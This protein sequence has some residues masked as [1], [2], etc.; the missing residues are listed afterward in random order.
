MTLGIFIIYQ[1]QSPAA[2]I[3]MFYTTRQVKS[4]KPKQV[5]TH[6]MER[7][8]S[9]EANRFSASPEIPRI[10]W[11]PKVHYRIHKCLPTVLIL[12]LLDPVHIPTSY[13]LKIHLN[14][15]LPSTPGSPKWSFSF[16]FPPPKPCIRLSCP[17]YELHATPNSFFSILSPEQNNTSTSNCNYL[18]QEIKM[19]RL[20]Y[21]WNTSYFMLHILINCSCESVVSS[22]I[23]N[24][25]HFTDGQVYTEI[26]TKLIQ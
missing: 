6:S 26:Y 11:N 5:Q 16:S 2:V 25:I 10:V 12:S 3:V 17:P 21:R 9:W 20:M 15:I 8:P 23:L 24:D 7:S 19:Y 4:L 14:I 22:S 13:F 18:Q 1:T